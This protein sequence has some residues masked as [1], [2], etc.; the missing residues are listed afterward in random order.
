VAEVPKLLT[1]KEAAALLR[2]GRTTLY[3]GALATGEL[4]SIR[5]GS[6]RLIRADDLAAFIEASSAG[7]ERAAS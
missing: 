7:V 5:I 4:P 6:R 2:L 1:V 3:T